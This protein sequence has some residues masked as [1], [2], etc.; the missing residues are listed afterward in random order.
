VILAA[1]EVSEEQLR[2][3]RR[4]GEHAESEIDDVDRS[5]IVEVPPMANC[6]RDRHLP[7][8][9]HEVLLNSAH[10]PSLL[11]EP[12]CRTKFSASPTSEDV[13]RITIRQRVRPL[14]Q[15]TRKMQIV[16]VSKVSTSS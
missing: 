13:T 6:G 2:L 14:Y 7:R 16:Q 10:G 4:N 8:S 12:L 3:P 9:R 11:G 5:S 1:E 15:S